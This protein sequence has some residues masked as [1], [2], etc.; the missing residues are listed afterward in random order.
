MVGICQWEGIEEG[1]CSGISSPVLLWDA[2]SLVVSVNGLAGL[3]RLTP[4]WTGFCT[5]PRGLN[6]RGRTC[7][8]SSVVGLKVMR[9]CLPA[10]L[11][12]GFSE[13]SPSRGDAGCLRPKIRP[14]RPPNLR[15]RSGTET[16]RVK[17]KEISSHASSAINATASVP[18]AFV[19]NPL[20]GVVL[21]AGASQALGVAFTPTDT[22]NYNSATGATTTRSRWRRS[23]S[24]IDARRMNA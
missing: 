16:S 17:A 12:E 22:V 9:A 6:S 4:P 23:C 3:S 5:S 11:Y 8:V 19:Y 10:T 1:I 24:S 7:E 20:A 14:I 13:V 15:S 18:G 2:C 21:N